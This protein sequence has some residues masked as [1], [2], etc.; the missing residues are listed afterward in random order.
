MDSKQPEVQDDEHLL[1]DE[2]EGWLSEAAETA[3]TE[4]FQRFDVDK[5][6]LLSFQE[7]QSFALAASG[8]KFTAKELRDLKDNE[9]LDA[10]GKW[11]L[12][13]FLSFFHLQ[14]CSHVCSSNS[15]SFSSYPPAPRNME[16]LEQVWL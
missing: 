5:D 9:L 6:G 8:R 1:L 13:G 2:E 11:T 15:T 16:G 3:F 7:I 10:Q 12:H 14:T 4:I